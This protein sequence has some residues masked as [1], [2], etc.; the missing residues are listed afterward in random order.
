MWNPRIESEFISARL[1]SSEIM[2]ASQDMTTERTSTRLRPH[3]AEE[4]DTDLSL[5]SEAKHS[6]AWFST[7]M[8][9][10]LGI[11]GKLWADFSCIVE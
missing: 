5:I 3:R 1:L 6:R 9:D 8:G 11:P 7:W 2:T 4:P 10:R